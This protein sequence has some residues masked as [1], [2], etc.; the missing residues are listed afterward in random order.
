[1]L[2]GGYL[3][4]TERD[5]DNAQAG[6]RLNAERLLSGENPS[7]GPV[8]AAAVNSSP[9]AVFMDLVSYQAR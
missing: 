3:I 1:L 9:D 4:T 5:L 2:M 6:S 7:N 8:L